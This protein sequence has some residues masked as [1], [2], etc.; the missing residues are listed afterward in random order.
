MK[1]SKNWHTP[2]SSKGTGDSYGTGIKAKVGKIRDVYPVE[3]FN[4]SP[5]N[6]GKPPKSFA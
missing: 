5:K 3:G 2:R 4:Q 1:T 6:N